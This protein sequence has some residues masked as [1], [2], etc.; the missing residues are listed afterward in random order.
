MKA[1][2]SQFFNKKGIQKDLTLELSEGENLLESIREGMIQNK[3]NKAVLKAIQGKINNCCV[4]FMLGSRFKS[5]EIL[6]AN[7]LN[8]SGQYELKGKNN[9]LFGNMHLVFQNEKNTMTFVKGTAAE[10]LKIV[11]S[12]VHVPE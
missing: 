11:L 5:K 2:D 1:G 12:F 6:L 7:V 10:G 8:A 9:E 3:I 4:N